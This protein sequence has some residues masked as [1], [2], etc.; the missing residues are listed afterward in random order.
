VSGSVKA[1]D[2]SRNCSQKIGIADLDLPA[3]CCAT[4]FG[5]IRI[6]DLFKVEKAASRIRER[7]G[8]LS[9]DTEASNPIAFT[10]AIFVAATSAKTSSLSWDR[11]GLSYRTISLR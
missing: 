2:R 11:N 7:Y 3:K 8:R 1:N 10:I 5:N 4:P 6:I 9:L